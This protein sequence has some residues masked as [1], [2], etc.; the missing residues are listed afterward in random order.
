MF[1]QTIWN[2]MV[3]YKKMYYSENYETLIHYSNF[4][5]KNAYA[6]TFDNFRD[7]I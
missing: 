4:M 3:L 6:F 5:L 2:I 1:G 7:Q